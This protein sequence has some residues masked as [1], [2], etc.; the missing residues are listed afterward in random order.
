MM[1]ISTELMILAAIGAVFGWL[2][3]PDSAGKAAVFVMAFV[4]WVASRVC[5][6]IEITKEKPNA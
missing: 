5:K 4:F 3:I 2:I 6:C 1:K